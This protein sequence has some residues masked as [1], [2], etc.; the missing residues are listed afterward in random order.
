ME[1]HWTDSQDALD[2]FV[3]GSLSDS[4]ELRF[5]RHLKECEICHKKVLMFYLMYYAI[6]SNARME[7]KNDITIQLILAKKQPTKKVTFKYKKQL[8]IGIIS[9]VVI[10]LIFTLSP[11]VI[12]PVAVVADGK[13]GKYSLKNSKS[14]TDADINESEFTKEVVSDK[15][16]E[17]TEGLSISADSSV[18]S[19]NATVLAEEDL[20]LFS[21]L[22]KINYVSKK[23]KAEPVVAK[24]FN[25]PILFISFGEKPK[26]VPNEFKVKFVTNK[27]HQLEKMIVYLHKRTFENMNYNVFKIEKLTLIRFNTGHQYINS[28]EKPFLFQKI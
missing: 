15:L 9:L 19:E 3:L 11:L 1:E 21:H 8:F 27:N 7:L 17:N 10:L 22:K 5:S 18:T 26:T 4:D 2:A 14:M 28:N 24:E 12:T 16:P 23:K 25:V 6:R 20:K 13:T